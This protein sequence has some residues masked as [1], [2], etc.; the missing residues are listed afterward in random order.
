MNFRE[1][2]LNSVLII[3]IKTIKVAPFRID[4]DN[5]HIPAVANQMLDL[6]Q[7]TVKEEIES[8]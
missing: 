3:N 8:P 1:Y 6:A 5:D 7:D 2:L 4:I